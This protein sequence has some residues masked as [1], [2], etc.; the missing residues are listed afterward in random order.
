MG[1]I[2]SKQ[3]EL[4]PRKKLQSRSSSAKLIKEKY[5]ISN[6]VLGSGGF[7]KV[8]EATLQ[9]DKDVKFAIKVISKK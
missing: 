4:V 7:G 1:C 8:F 9:S 6:Q 3:K 5:F 2:G